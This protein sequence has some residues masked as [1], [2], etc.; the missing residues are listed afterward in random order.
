M[1]QYEANASLLSYPPDAH[2]ALNDLFEKIPD[3]YHDKISID[4]LIHRFL[5]E[6]VL[7][8]KI[9]EIRNNTKDLASFRQR[10]YQWFNLFICFKYMHFYRDEVQ[11]NISVEEAAASLLDMMGES[12]KGKSARELLEKFREIEKRRGLRM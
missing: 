3:L 12:T 9:N 5:G 10:F 7:L 4:P 8:K 11:A 6:G 1:L 2:L